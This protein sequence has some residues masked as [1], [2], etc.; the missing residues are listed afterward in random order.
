MACNKSVTLNFKGY[1][2]QQ[3]EEETQRGK[4]MFTCKT[5]DKMEEK[6]SRESY[7]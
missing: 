4:P 2:Q 1:L 7:D 3:L 6:T 5:A